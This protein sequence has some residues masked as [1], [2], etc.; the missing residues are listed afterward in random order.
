M[1][2]K[3]TC[4][5]A[6]YIIHCALYTVDCP[7]DSTANTHHY[8][9]RGYFTAPVPSL[10]STEW[11]W[12]M[13]HTPTIF[14]CL[15]GTSAL[16]QGLLTIHHGTSGATYHRM[17]QPHHAGRLTAGQCWPNLHKE[18]RNLL[19]L[20]FDICSGLDAAIPCPS[21]S[22]AWPALPTSPV[23]SGNHRSAPAK[24]QGD[25][26]PS[27][28]RPSD[29][30]GFLYLRTRPGRP[31]VGHKTSILRSLSARFLLMVCE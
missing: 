5:L 22:V 24:R 20:N 7:F 6:L 21:P 25:V 28:A 15:E 14:R 12:L 30:R 31:S 17:H 3:K 9:R 16:D 1:S 19:S 8:F 23:C 4:A 11:G 10:P 18:P 27:I 29:G 26:T 13:Y 2:M